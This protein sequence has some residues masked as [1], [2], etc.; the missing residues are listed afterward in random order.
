MSRQVQVRFLIA[1]IAAAI[2][3]FVRGTYDEF[4]MDEGVFH[5]VNADAT[6]AMKN[7]IPG[8]LRRKWS[9]RTID[10]KKYSCSTFMLYL[11]LEGEVDLPHHTIYTSRAYQ[12]NLRDIG[13]G[14]LTDDASTYVHNPS[15]LDPT[16]APEGHSSLYVLV[17]TPNNQA[18]IDW[19]TEGARYREETLD[20]LE[21]VFGIAGV[22]DRIRAEAPTTAEGRV[23]LYMQLAAPGVYEA[24]TKSRFSADRPW[25]VTHVVAP[26]GEGKAPEIHGVDITDLP[27]SCVY[28]DGLE[29]VIQMPGP[30]LLARDVL[31]GDNALGVPVFPAGEAP[32]AEELLEARLRFALKRM[33]QSLPEDI[34]GASYAFRFQGWPVGVEGALPEAQATGEGQ[35]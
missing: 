11:G 3:W 19:S 20:R 8:H 26:E 14:R 12:Q 25:I 16:L 27:R 18:D 23:Q 7:L 15:R 30:S 34:A 35:G 5:V 31:V 33:M 17:P 10:G 21:T 24:L 6:W 32:P 1:A 28:Q 13:E 29:V 4:Q 9:D 22:R 2:A